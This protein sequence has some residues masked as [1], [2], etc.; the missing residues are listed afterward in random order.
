[1]N[2]TDE[3]KKEINKLIKLKIGEQSKSSRHV[4]A[5]TAISS[6]LLIGVIFGILIWDFKGAEDSS[7]HLWKIAFIGII[8]FFGMLMISSY[9]SEH[10]PH[11]IKGSKGVMRRG[12]ISSFVVVYFIVLSLVLFE[13]EGVEKT[14]AAEKILENFTS[15]I[16]VLIGFYFGSKG[17]IELYKQVRGNNSDSESESNDNEEHNHENGEQSDG[18]SKIIRGSET[19]SN[20]KI[21]YD[22]NC[23]KVDEITLD[24]KSNILNVQLQATKNGTLNISIPRTLIDSKNNGDD[25]NFIILVDG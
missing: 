17:A 23:G 10:H 22:I 7:I 8:T 14:S 20:K 1:M 15:I 25:D 12:I 4:Y 19:I 2:F 9:H 11:H 21:S 6:C 16:I 18:D 5:V 24:K 13:T 3:Q